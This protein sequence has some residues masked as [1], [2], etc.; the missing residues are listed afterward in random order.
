MKANQRKREDEAKAA[1]KA[2]EDARKQKEQAR[3]DAAKAKEQARSRKSANARR[4]RDADA[5]L[6]A[7]ARSALQKE[8]ERKSRPPPLTPPTATAPSIPRIFDSLPHRTCP[9]RPTKT[10]WPVDSLTKRTPLFNPF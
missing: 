4:L 5:M 7:N 2:K 3:K 8:Q 1:E 6:N 10:R 9:T